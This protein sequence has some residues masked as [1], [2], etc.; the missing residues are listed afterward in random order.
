MPEILNG[1]AVWQPG[2]EH[3]P[4]KTQQ[5]WMHRLQRC[6]AVDVI[7]ISSEELD[8]RSQQISEQIGW[9]GNDYRALRLFVG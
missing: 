5:G 4:L 7:P 6:A 1:G 2:S 8:H 9:L 3:P